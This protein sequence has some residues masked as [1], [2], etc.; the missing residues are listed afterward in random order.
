MR[1]VRARLA[2]ARRVLTLAGAALLIGAALFGPA[3][4]L[5]AQEPVGTVAADGAVLMALYAAT[6]G[7]NWTDNAN[8]GSDAP[9]GDWHGVSVNAEGRITGLQLKWNNL[10]GTLPPALGD[11][12][13][14][15]DLDLSYNQLHGP[16]FPPWLADP[17]QP[18]RTAPGPQSV[19]WT[20]SARIGQLHQPPDPQ[21]VLQPAER[22]DP[23]R[24]RQ[25]HQPWGNST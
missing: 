19:Q 24:T 21:P 13:A 18:A 20:D 15:E 22:R 16:V 5:L 14:L 8:W 2:N 6:D 9:L 10:T 12:T 7:P 3:P 1:Q 25:P 4:S 23:A 17:A 11:L